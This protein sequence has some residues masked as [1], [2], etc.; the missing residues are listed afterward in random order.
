LK[1]AFFDTSALASVLFNEPSS[2]AVRNILEDIGTVHASNLMEAEIRSAAARE[3]LDQREVDAVLSKVEWVLPD[4]SLS[5]ELRVVASCG[6]HLRGADLWHVACALYLAGDPSNL[7]F[8][9]LDEGQAAAAAR[10]GFRVLPS[11]PETAAREKP[12]AYG[13]VVQKVNHQGA[14]NR[15]PK[16]PFEP[17]RAPRAPRTTKVKA[18]L[19]YGKKEK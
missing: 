3:G 19:G 17:R 10:L 16:R 11:S 4:R 14:K 18:H 6:I 1:A 7:P 12:A 13:T 8:V 15:S 9:T 5:P 2:P